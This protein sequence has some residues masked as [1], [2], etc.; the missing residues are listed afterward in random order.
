MYVRRAGPILACALTLSACGG[1]GTSSPAPSSSALVAGRVVL[2]I[3][4]TSGAAAARKPQYISPSAV[5]VSIVV[6]GGAPT[7]AD[8]SATSPDCTTS[9]Q[10]RVCTIPLQAP[11]GNDTFTFNQYDGANATGHLLGSGTA[12]ATVVAGQA[13]QIAATLNGT[14]ASITLSIG[15]LPPAG[16]PG[17][18]ALTVTAKDAAGDTI[19]GPG[20][21]TTPITLSVV[22][23]TGQTS[24][25]TSTITAPSATPVT[26]NY[27]GG[28]GVNATITGS[29]A[30]ATPGSVVFAPT[31]GGLNLYVS[32]FG[33]TS[34]TVTPASA[35]GNAAPARTI[36]GSNTQLSQNYDL[37]VDGS[38]NTYVSNLRGGAITVYASGA[39]GN[40][41]PIRTLSGPA[42][43][44]SG[45]L[46]L[47]IDGSGNLVEDNF[48]ASSVNVFAPGANGNA[49][50]IRTLS[51]GNTNLS[52]VYGITLDTAGNLYVVDNNSQFGG[53]DA[54]TVY[55]AGFSGN[56]APTQTITGSNTGMSG[57]AFVA[58]DA[59]GRIYV[60]N[61]TA[62]S[63]TVYAAGANGN[64]APVATIAGANTT[65]VKPGGIVIDASGTIYVG[66]DAGNG[67]DAIVVFAAGAN[68][69]VAP[70][71]TIRGATTGLSFPYGMKLAP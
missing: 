52:A 1:G 45:A 25:S 65:L 16:A 53:T 10:S 3:A 42:T 70:L 13:F 4:Q 69:N 57:A 12:T 36:A 22:D 33:N 31:G 20:N 5:S 49:T 66:N 6:N 14:V 68:G 29:A 39:N 8:I 58:V 67:N 46:G 40:V 41:A 11:V 56:V 62:N 2:T 64:A 47:A 27:A 50:P 63:V 43:G 28:L 59:G 17:T 48:F 34:I 38:G 71:R 54:V 60:T 35:S 21:Y 61:V 19:V 26:I 7:I 18:A 37:A 51:G 23:P 55:A 44:V 24:L 9:G 32:E 30:G 15:A